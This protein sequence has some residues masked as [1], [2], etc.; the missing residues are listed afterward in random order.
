VL[1]RPALRLEQAHLA[2]TAAALAAADACSDVAGFRPWLKWPNDL[3][4]A[5]DGADRKLAGMLA[6]TLVDGRRLE[7]VVV[8]IGLNVN[9]PAPQLA[10]FPAATSLNQVV[11]HDVDR[12]ELLVAVLRRL[13]RRYAALATAAGRQSTMSQYRRRC[14]TI[15]RRVRVALSDELLVGRARDVDG[16]G[17]LEVEAPGGEVRL[18]ASGDVVHLRDDSSPP[19]RSGAR[20]EG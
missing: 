19:A 3:V 2:L 6:D 18:V 5:V 12:D 8:G 7:A 15:G 13:E 4:V 17:R 10:H 16:D 20:P 11:G 14:A 1:L 9:W